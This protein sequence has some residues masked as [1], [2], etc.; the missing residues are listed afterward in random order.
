MA[1]IDNL[2][3][4]PQRDLYRRQKQLEVAP[5]MNNTAID[6]DAMETTTDAPNVNIGADGVMRRC[7]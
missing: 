4:D 5:S 3:T 7:V 1:R 2:N 6:Y